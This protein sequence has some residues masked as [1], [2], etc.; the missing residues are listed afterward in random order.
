MATQITEEISCP[1]CGAAVKTELWPGVD[2]AQN[3]DR[4]ARVLNET[5]FDW[6]CPEC[7]YTARFLYPFLYHDPERNYMV[8]LSPNGGGCEEIDLEKEFPQLHGVAKRLVTTPEALKEK[9]LIFD[10]GLDDRAVELVKLALAGVLDQKHGK[11]AAAGYFCY[12]DE[13]KNEIGFSFLLEGEDKPVR[14]HTRMEAY[15]KSVEIVEC[16]G[17]VPADGFVPVDGMTAQ[18]I[19]DHYHETRPAE[20]QER[21]G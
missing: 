2:A 14:R 19:L 4:K 5:M 11:K 7:G 21:K 13:S 16:A 8:Y 1:Q 20:E 10:A 17:S 15:Q 6:S 12:A 3:P 9:I 18:T